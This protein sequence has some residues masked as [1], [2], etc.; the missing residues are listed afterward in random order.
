MK[1]GEACRVSGMRPLVRREPG[2]Q[3]REGMALAHTEDRT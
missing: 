1:K 2:A 3:A